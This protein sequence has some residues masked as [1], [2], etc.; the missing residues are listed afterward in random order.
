MA[1]ASDP[2]DGG[3]AVSPASP[4]PPPDEDAAPPTPQ[5]AGGAPEAAEDAPDS[6]PGPEATFERRKEQEERE[7]DDRGYDDLRRVHQL[8]NNNFYGGVDASGAAFGFGATSSPGLAPGT[9]EPDEADRALRF[10]VPPQHCFDEALGKLHEG[11]LVVLTGPDNCGRGAGS[12]ALL[13]KILGEGARLRSLSP[14]NALAELAASRDLKPGQGYVILDYVGEL[15]AEAVQVYEIGRLSEEL[16]RKGS[17]L[18]ITAGDTARRRLALRDHCVPW[19][20]PDPVELFDHCREKLPYA[21]LEPDTETEL[22][23]RVGEQ[24]RPADVVAAA[25]ALSR[26]GPQAALETLRDRHRELV[27]AWFRKRPDA[28]DLLALA[29]LAFLEG[30]PERTFEKQ[31]AAL[32]AHVRNWEQSGETPVAEPDGPAGAPLSGAV[33]GQSRARWRERAVGLVTTESRLG[34]SRDSGRS[35]RCL[36][37]T[38]PR[39]RELVIEELHDLYGY[40][41]WYPLRQW[42]GELALL[43]DLDTRA[44][45]ARGV[46]LLARY[47]LVEVDENLLQ[48]WSD[49]IT[50]QRVTAALTLQFM[51]GVEHLAP[52][53]RNIVLGWVDNRGAGRAVTAAMA[54][55]GRLGSLYRLEALNW[56][57]FLANRGERV[58]FSARR[59]LVLLLQT[60]EQDPERALLI[61]RYVRTVIAKAGPGSRERSIALRTAVQ[62]LEANRLEA[63]SEP[64]TAALLRTVPDSARHLGS[65]WAH[66]LHSSSRSRAVS[67]LCRTL[68]HLREDPSVTGAVQEL[69]EAMRNAMSPRQWT[70]LRHHLSIALKHPDYAIPGAGQLAQVLLGSLRGRA[71][72]DSRRSTQPLT[73]SR[74]TPPFPSAQGGRSK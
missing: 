71:S 69:G 44:E 54:L 36:V 32:A 65:L 47:A 26:K 27:Q 17:Y 3:P 51:C 57:W 11:A 2:A 30:I 55:T 14:A 24:R 39:I 8:V 23:E 20:A 58:A 7:E 16:R 5:D 19:R 43:G 1:D 48:V 21:G 70:A 33:T 64:F 63:P 25:V 12:L 53:A 67:A 56:L 9:I 18:V 35:E 74:S 15:H 52:Q 41:L 38:S 59:S 28:D 4:A 10:Y 31:C 13:R 34:P 68:V 40:E 60:A 62:L 42:L 66:V 22:L 61:L 37:F 29:A 46:A 73:S 72:A 49:G 50:S 6:D 45:V